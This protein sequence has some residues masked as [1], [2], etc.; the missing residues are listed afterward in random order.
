MLIDAGEPC[1]H[2]LKRMGVDFNSLDAVYITHSHSDH[3][4]GLP[5]LLQSCWL[6]QRRRP[7]PV[8][9][10][11]GVIQPFRDWIRCC[12]LLEDKLGFAIE[13]KPIA[14]CRTT[15]LPEAYCLSFGRRFAYS[16]DIGSPNDLDPLF[17]VETLV[18][19]LA[20]FHPQTLADYLK[21][22]GLRQLILTHIGRPARARLPEVRAL[23]PNAH[24]ANDGDCLPI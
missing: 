7:L 17:P 22:K 10:P 24:I 20:H 12:H 4:G 6:E 23:F 21:D 14:G 8:H 16:G 1:S 18:V 2:T 13:W 5:M 15:H 19:E 9:L 11:A 3:I